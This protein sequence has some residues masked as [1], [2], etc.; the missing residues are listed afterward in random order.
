MYFCVVHWL[1]LF[2]FKTEK[3][4]ESM[5]MYLKKLRKIT[6]INSWQLI[7]IEHIKKYII[8]I[9]DSRQDVGKRSN[10]VLLN[11][12]SIHSEESEKLKAKWK[13]GG[14]S[15]S[16]LGKRYLGFEQ[17]AILG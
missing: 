11:L 2:Y 9:V 17:L 6:N 1:K 8:L 10:R 7:K 15:F 13:Q 3:F 16:E 4:S 5:V 12:F 14:H